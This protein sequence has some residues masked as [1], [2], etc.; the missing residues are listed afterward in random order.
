MGE[1]VLAS[2]HITEEER[3]DYKIVG[4]G[5]DILSHAV[6]QGSIDLSKVAQ[7]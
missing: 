1:D 2:T 3:G 4:R 5:Q 7:L 6:Q